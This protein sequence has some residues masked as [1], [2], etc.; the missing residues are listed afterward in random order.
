MKPVVIRVL[1]TSMEWDVNISNLGRDA[2]IELVP[3]DSEAFLATTGCTDSVT[4]EVVESEVKAHEAYDAIM[5]TR[6][7]AL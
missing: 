1:T 4:G 6:D 3:L 7:G 5:A 2:P